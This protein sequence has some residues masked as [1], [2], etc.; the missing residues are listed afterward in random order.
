M[1]SQIIN[2]KNIAA[3]QQHIKDAEGQVAT[4]PPNPTP[5]NTNPMASWK[6]RISCHFS[7]ILKVVTRN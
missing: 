1:M 3:F 7:Y 5:R 2:A 6:E 4:M